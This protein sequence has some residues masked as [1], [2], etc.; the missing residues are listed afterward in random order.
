MTDTRPKLPSPSG[1]CDTHMHIFE[2]GYTVM[3]GTNLPS[4]PGTIAEYRKLRERLGITR[5]VIVQPAAYGR[6]NRCTL[7]AMQ[8]LAD[9]G[10]QTRGVAIVLPDDSDQHIAALTAAGEHGYLARA[11]DVARLDDATVLRDHVAVEVARARVALLR[12]AVH[13][14]RAVA[15]EV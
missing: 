5:T 12:A 13:E 6:D 15:A 2:P 4:M 8:A 7:A 11:L 10:H 9:A 3:P 1:T 14:P